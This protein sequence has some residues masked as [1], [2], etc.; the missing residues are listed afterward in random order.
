MG[1]NLSSWL[2]QHREEIEARWPAVAQDLPACALLS[3]DEVISRWRPLIEALV[4][5]NT[6]TLARK[7]RLWAAQEMRERGA[8]PSEILSIA[9]GLAHTVRDLLPAEGN[10]DQVNGRLND[11]TAALAQQFASEAEKLA[12]D[13]AQLETLYGIT[14]ELSSGLDLRRALQKALEELTIAVNAERGAVFLVDDAA[15]QIVPEARVRWDSEATALRAFPS[16]WQLGRPSPP[17]VFNDLQAEATGDWVTTLA[18]PDVASLIV[19]PLI[20]NGEFRGLLAVG[21]SRTD[22]FNPSHARLF[23]NVLGQIATAIGN[24]EVQRFISNQAKELGEMLRH[25]QEES[26]KSQAILTSIV[27]GVVVN[28][29]AGQIILVNPM[30]ERI[31]SMAANQLLGQDFRALFSVFN[32]KGEEEAVGAMETL[33]GTTV[34]AVT[35]EFKMRLVVDS[36]IIHAHLSPV[37][38][39]RDD[40]LGVVTVFRDITKEVEADRA[41]S[42]FVSTVSHE[43]RTPMTSIKGYTDLLYAGAAGTITVEQQ[44]FLGIIKSNTDRLTALINDLLDI[45]RMETGRLRFEP[46]PLQIGEVI[47]DVVNAL[48]GQAEVKKQLLSYEVIGRLPDIVGDRDRLNQVLTNLVSNAIHYTPEG[49]E[50]EVQAYAI[51]G[52][53]RVDVRDTGIGIPPEDLGH[54]FERFYR[55]DHPLVQEQRG[56]GLG[57]SIV[58]MFVEMHGG[59]IWVESEPDKGSTFTF[60]LPVPVREEEDG[61]WPAP[62]HLMARIRTILVVDDDRD[63]AALTQK[64]LENAGYGVSIMGRG[65][66]VVEWAEEHQPDLIIL[67]LILP[68]VGGLEVLRDL[69][70]GSLTT[71]IPVIV[72]TIVPDDGTAWDGGIVDYLTKPVEA[73]DLLKSVERGLTWQGRILI[74]EDDPDTVGLLSATVRQIGFTPL[75][76]IDGY[77]ALAAAR[78]QRP[79]LIL[80]DLR[81]PGMDGFEALTHLKRDAVTQ[82][83]PIIAISAHV[84]NVDQ[85]RKRLVAL[86]AASFLPKPFSIGE[87]LSEIEVA[88]QPV[89]SGPPTAQ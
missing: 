5:E 55:A 46:Q 7:A 16:E 81:L 3:G 27:D 23:R 43:L 56:T 13:R 32:T 84:S 34:P 53:V 9:D 42:E 68:D 66:S 49:G 73:E 65:R 30:A 71:D 1:W 38:T 47:A 74:V 57:L 88:L 62:K 41:K 10:L 59:R 75:V 37:L 86:G 61:R 87:L 6:E 11:L 85:E 40:F 28:D 82:A 36:R 76:A 21:N 78:R 54:V 39:E 45:S 60:I 89:S 25:Q 18:G 51:E 35:K 31:L 26:T 67:D 69:R 50:I 83:I 29:T 15:G 58:K 48:A 80:L 8:A 79:N 33:L 22:A 77:E 4:A 64:Q 14:R 2:R 24:A 20:A 17:L 19:A 70:D 12:L 44:R 52:T 63:I 72:H